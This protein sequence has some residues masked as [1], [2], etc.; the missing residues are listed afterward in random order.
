MA[1]ASGDSPTSGLTFQQSTRL[2]GATIPLAFGTGISIAT[3]ASGRPRLFEIQIP[4]GRVF[5]LEMGES[6]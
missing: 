6:D 4:K 3:D 5:L 2:S 1:D